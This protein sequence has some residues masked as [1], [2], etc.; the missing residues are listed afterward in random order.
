MTEV[1]LRPE[2]FRLATEEASD[3]MIITNPE[4]VVVYANEA[5]ANE[6]YPGDRGNEPG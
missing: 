6:D 1:V 4:G 2:I 3:H 5:A